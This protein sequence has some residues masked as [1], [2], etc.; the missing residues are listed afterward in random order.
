MKDSLFKGTKAKYRIEV[1]SPGF[2]MSTDNFTVK[3]T[4]G[5]VSQTFQKSDLIDKVV[6]ENGVSKHEYYVC[7][8]SATFGVGDILV[9]INAYVPDTDFAGGTRLEIDKFRLINVQP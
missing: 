2:D 6:I 1:E 5:S 4:C 8:D 9:Q 7:F 3:L